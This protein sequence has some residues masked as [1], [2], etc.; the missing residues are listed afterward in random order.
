MLKS[1]Q[2]FNEYEEKCH[3]Y[4]KWLTNIN[5]RRLNRPVYFVWL[6]DQTEDVTYMSDINPDKLIL[7]KGKKVVGAYDYLKLF[8]YLNE[9]KNELPDPINT[10]TWLDEVNGL[11][12]TPVTEYCLD[13]IEDSLNGS[14][15]NKASIYESINFI[16]LYNDLADQLE[17]DDDF[18]NLSRKKDIR[19]L[20]EF[21]YDEIFWKEWG[22]EEL[23]AVSIP[24]FTANYKLLTKGMT[25]MIEAFI[26][27][28]EII[29]QQKP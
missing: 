17:D 26:N 11:D 22:H 3:L 5:S 4:W 9:H 28:I 13:I 19:K 7:T 14:G 15:F 8:Q 23:P 12:P 6:T 21:G 27:Q 29:D 20:W 24:K 2:I 18:Y 25:K 10:L 16:N 1:K